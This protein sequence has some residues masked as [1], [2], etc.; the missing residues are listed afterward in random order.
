MME[1]KQKV[2]VT[3]V[4]IPFGSMVSLMVKWSLAAIPAAIILFLIY[5]VLA[6]LFGS[7]MSGIGG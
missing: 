3:D 1:D 6:A 7:C 2:V 5:M 4:H